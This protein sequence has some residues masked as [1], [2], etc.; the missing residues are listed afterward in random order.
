MTSRGS[1]RL[2]QATEGQAQREPYH[3]TGNTVETMWNPVA[4]GGD[5]P[6]AFPGTTAPYFPG[7]FPV[8]GLNKG[9]CISMTGGN[10]CGEWEVSLYLGMSTALE[11]SDACRH[12]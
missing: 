8:V 2:G 10:D 4:L 6:N 3:P 1:S 5:K 12:P 7:P 11:C 9:F